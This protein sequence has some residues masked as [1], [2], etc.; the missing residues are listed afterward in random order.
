MDYP[1]VIELCSR[2]HL[3]TSIRYTDI[4]LLSKNDSQS[5][6]PCSLSKITKISE[7][8]CCD[9]QLHRRAVGAFLM[10]I[11]TF[12][13]SYIPT[14]V[15]SYSTFRHLTMHYQRYQVPG[16]LSILRPEVGRLFASHR[17]MPP[18]PPSY[19]FYCT[20]ETLKFDFLLLI[21]YYRYVIVHMIMTS[22][23]YHDYVRLRYS[24][25]KKNKKTSNKKIM[26]RFTGE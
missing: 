21:Y 23:E 18:L 11:P 26:L 16:L 3:S 22:I 7:T 17:F 9:L 20:H 5:C 8:D 12:L 13:H 2:C 19:T 1:L 15:R 4:I 25:P 24:T 6:L 14:F 10:V